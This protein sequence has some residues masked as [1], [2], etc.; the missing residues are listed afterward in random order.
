MIAAKG[1]TERD[2]GR[3]EG[4][5][6]SADNGGSTGGGVSAKVLGQPG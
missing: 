2:V 5:G 4:D 1:G 6:L 3:K